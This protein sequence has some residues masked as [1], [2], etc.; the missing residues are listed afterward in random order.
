M[1]REGQWVLMAGQWFA[2]VVLAIDVVVSTGRLCDQ[3]AFEGLALIV[4]C[5]M[6]GVNVGVFGPE[7]LGRAVSATQ[8]RFVRFVGAV[9]IGVR[10]GSGY[11]RDLCEGKRAVVCCLCLCGWNGVQG[12]NSGSNG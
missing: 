8:L 2:V 9:L 1:R 11:R 10:A 4:H 5:G 12:H 6:I 7:F 3:I